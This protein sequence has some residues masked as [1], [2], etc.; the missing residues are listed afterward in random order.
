MREFR[1]G[2]HVWWSWHAGEHPEEGPATVVEHRSHALVFPYLL[3]LPSGELMHATA[4]EV[5]E[6][7]QA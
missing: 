7:P 3:R 5:R 4:D 1:V 2:D 6:M